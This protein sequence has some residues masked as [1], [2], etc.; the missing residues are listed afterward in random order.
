MLKSRGSIAIDSNP[1]SVFDLIADPN[2]RGE[3]AEG[4]EQMKFEPA[5]DP[6]NPIGAKFILKIREGRSVNEY[7]GEVTEFE[8]PRVLALR[9]S[10]GLVTMEMG[11]RLTPDGSGTLVET[12]GDMRFGSWYTKVLGVLFGWYAW[13]IARN[14]LKKLK[15]IAESG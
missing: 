12:F 6:E 10:R 14:Q 4:V 7:A 8:R 9:V 15:Q 11:H 13:R 1:E 3:W 2:R 5:F